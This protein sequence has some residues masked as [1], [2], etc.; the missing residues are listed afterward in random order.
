MVSAKTSSRITRT[1]T[2]GAVVAF[3]FL[4]SCNS[5]D[6]KPV[7]QPELITTVTITF[8]KIGVVEEPV[9][10]T[11]KDLD[12][13]GSG[14]PV[15]DNIVLDANSEYEFTLTLL[16]ESGNPAEDI[17]AEIKS[18]DEEH[19]FFFSSTVDGVVTSYGDTDSNGKPV[20]LENT[21]VTDQTGAGTFRVIL[22]HEPDKTA[23]GV[24]D[25]DPA[26]AGGET[27]VDTSFPLTIVE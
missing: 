2:A 5:D 1:L 17:T 14:S 8:Q 7:E 26:N 15:V 6:P 4:S 3:I 16:D 11:W 23:A 20:G 27:D 21:I 12:G 22:I 13:S 10:Y 19:Q 18:E 25:G 9:S 24:S